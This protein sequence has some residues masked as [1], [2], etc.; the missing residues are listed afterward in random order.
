MTQEQLASAQ[1]EQSAARGP[2]EPTTASRIGRYLVLDRLGEGAMGVVLRGFDTRLERTVAIKLIRADRGEARGPRDERARARLVAE[3]R[4]LAR[5]SHPNVVAVYEVDTH[6]DQ[7]YVAMELVEGIDLQRYLRRGNVGWREIV[8]IFVALAEGLAAVHAAGIVHRDFKPA[9]VLI[10]ADGRPRIGDFGI[11]RSSLAPLTHSGEHTPSGDAEDDLVD[12]ELTS[13]TAEGHVVGTPAYMA[14]EQHAGAEVGPAADQYAFAVSLWEA[15]YGKRPFLSDVRRLAAAKRKPPRAPPPGSKV[16]RWLFDVLARSLEPDPGRRFGSMSELAAALRRDRGLRRRRV[17]FAAATLAGVV[18]GATMMA[19]RSGPCSDAQQQLAGIWDR[20]GRDAV[21]AAF[22]ASARPWAPQ[23]WSSVAPELDD[24]A[25]RWIAA[26][27]DA[28]EATRVRGEQSEAMLDKRMA[29][30]AGR[31]RALAATVELLREGTDEAVDH[32]QTVVERLRPLD[33]CADVATLASG[34]AM[35]DDPAL[36]DAVAAVRDDVERARVATVAGRLADAKALAHDASERARALQF[37]PLVA[38]A[39]AV[40]GATFEQLEQIPEARA[41]YEEAVWSALALGLDEVAT[42]AASGMVWLASE[43]ERNFDEAMRWSALAH[44]VLRRSGTPASLAARLGNAT[45]AAYSSFGHL[46]QA[47]VHFEDA[48]A[49]VAD[50]PSDRLLA[51]ALGSNLAKLR[52]DSGDPQGARER[53][54]LELARLEPLLGEGHPTVLRVRGVLAAIIDHLGDHDLATAMLESVEK[55][56]VPIYGEHSAEVG[57]TLVNLALA[58]HR[59]RRNDQALAT[60]LRA[61]EIF[62][63]NGDAVMMATCL[64]NIGDEY[65]DRGV[66]DAAMHDFERAEALLRQVYGDDSSYIVLPMVGVGRILLARGRYDEALA[67]FERIHR[68]VASLDPDVREAGAWLEGT[69]ASLIGL[70]RLD[71]ALEAA[72]RQVAFYSALPSR[73]PNDVPVARGD[74]AKVLL[75]LGRGDE[76]LPVLELALAETR[77]VHDPELEADLELDYARVLAQLGRDR[78][79]H[80]ALDR[81]TVAARRAGHRGHLERAVAI[82]EALAR[83]DTP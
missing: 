9:N 44:A 52:Y 20:P 55:A 18:A 19:A 62:E 36:H 71:E 29:C 69:T 51:F 14:P 45:G 68:I 17:A 46:E 37:E 4:A 2:A 3:A 23:A 73:Y 34:V 66:L 63:H 32:A 5:L 74:L 1:T 58:H 15:L 26:H 83:G 60:H 38:E 42:E 16:P 82:T 70:G 43:R 47:R 31:R 49:R 6:E 48:L 56:L 8:K 40:E 33:A 77:A 59:A 64:N 22:T 81:A 27:R 25:Q 13:L 72:R 78:E 75:A 39:L 11:A 21:A 10:G 76:A 41:A 24:Y 28:C 65:L 61:F 50:S 79:V 12:I 30:L 7:I 35:P 53:Y 67:Q 57:V 54:E 80:D